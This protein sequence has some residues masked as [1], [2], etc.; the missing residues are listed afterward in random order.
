VCHKRFNQA[1]CF[2]QAELKKKNQLTNPL[3]IKCK[4]IDTFS[5]PKT[6]KK[7]F[8]EDTNVLHTKKNGNVETVG[9]YL[10]SED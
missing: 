10:V 1:N 2:I 8:A 5:Y 4:K 3:C 6:N 7:S 9:L